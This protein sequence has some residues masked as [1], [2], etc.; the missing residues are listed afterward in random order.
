MG[1]LTIINR[2]RDAGEDLARDLNSDFI[3]MDEMKETEVDILINATSVGMFPDYEG[4][5]IDPS[6]IRKDI[7]VMDIVYNPLKTRFLKEAELKG[8]GIIDGLS[9][10]VQQGAFQFELW[11]GK[12]APV[13]LMRETVLKALEENR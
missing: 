3:Q 9:M 6:K 2:S 5:P 13:Q 7:L 4:I 10:F 11:T 8:C 1:Q 12:K